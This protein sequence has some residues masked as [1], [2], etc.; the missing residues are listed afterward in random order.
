MSK[1]RRRELIVEAVQLTS[2]N[3]REAMREVKNR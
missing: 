1:F 2:K 3:K